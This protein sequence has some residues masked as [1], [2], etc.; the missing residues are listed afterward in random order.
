MKKIFTYILISVFSFGNLEKINNDSSFKD[1]KIIFE[2]TYEGISAESLDENNV[3]ID[4]NTSSEV[5]FFIEEPMELKLMNFNRP[6][7]NDSVNVAQTKLKEIRQKTKEIIISNNL[8]A[9]EELKEIAPIEDFEIGTFSS[10]IRLKIDNQEL[11]EE[12]IETIQKKYNESE[13]INEVYI[14]EEITNIS[15]ELLYALPIINVSS[16]IDS[17]FYLGRNINV[18]IAESGAVLNVNNFSNDYYGRNI[19]IKSDETMNYY[20]AD[21]VAMVAVGNNGIARGSN[22][23]SAYGNPRSNYFVDW[24]ISNNVNLINTSYG[25]K[26][27]LTGGTYTSV[28]REIDQI[29]KYTFISFI[30]SSGNYE[31][32]KYESYNVTSPKTAYN[33]ITVGATS[34]NNPNSQKA[35]YSCYREESSYG[36]SKPNLMAPGTLTTNAVSGSGTSFAAPQVTGCLALLMEEYPYLI[37]YPE[38]CLSIVTSSAS[39]MST[40]YNANSGENV[41][42]SSGLHN[43]IGAGLLNYEKMREAAS[44]CLDIYRPANSS[45]GMLSDYIE[46][47]ANS[48]QRIRASLAWLANGTTTNN[49]TNYDLYLYKKNGNDYSLVKYINGA[50]NNVEFLDYNVQYSGTYRLAIIQKNS[51]SASDYLGLSYVLIDDSVG[52]SVSGGIETNYHEHTYSS[53]V[54]ISN[55]HHRG[56]CSCGETKDDVHVFSISS[57]P[58]VLGRCLVCGASSLGLNNTLI[59]YRKEYITNNGSYILSNGVIYLVEEDIDDY[60]NGSLEFIPYNFGVIV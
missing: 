12:F 10:V 59:N 31:E 19:V 49:I 23:Y 27:I 30:G 17:G 41:Y 16:M 21:A 39:P 36:G 5:R 25:D 9:L 26:N 2:G 1:K 34:A 33:Y 48:S 58:G 37:G 57:Q 40:I 54:S 38:L 7:K 60:F 6:E 35:S 32:N 11:N 24:F 3:V 18:G 44:R 4:N 45:T 28:A 50:T 52:G 22:I 56:T 47:N 15:N 53:Y 8:R 55:T 51:N 14:S 13:L 20:H 46:F 42:N 43:Q 29:I